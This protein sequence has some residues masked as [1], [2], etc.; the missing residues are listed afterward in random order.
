MRVLVQ[1]CLHASV[2]FQEEKRS[3]L[4]GFV[5]FVGFTPG[6]NE[7][8]IVALAKKVANLRIFEDE[9]GVMNESL[10][11]VSGSVLSISQFTLY[12]DASHGNRPSYIKAMKSEEAEKLYHLFN[13]ELGKYVPVTC[14]FFGK[15][16]AVEL[17]NLG[18]TTIL[19]EK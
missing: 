2:S 1:K 16:M 10:L 7:E 17:V 18:P 3:I 4:K 13:Q 19:L 12:G 6:D 5:L 15:D 8:K 14:G 11:D 9:Q